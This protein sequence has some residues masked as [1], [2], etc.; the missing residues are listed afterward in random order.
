[1]KYIELTEYERKLDQRKARLGYSGHDFVRPNSGVGRTPAKRT[2]LR[3]LA[4]AVRAAGRKPR[5]T[6]EP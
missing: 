2:L 3:K 5:F 6:A 4:E 1:V